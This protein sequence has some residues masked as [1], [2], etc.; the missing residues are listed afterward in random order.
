MCKF[1]EQYHLVLCTIQL[2]KFER[3]KI[4]NRKSQKWN[5]GFS[6]VILFVVLN[7]KKSHFVI[8]KKMHVTQG[9]SDFIL[10]SQV[11]NFQKLKNISLKAINFFSNKNKSNLFE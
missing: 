11:H 10:I 7:N 1:T 8:K 3:V 4:E 6:E 2:I 9:R 5:L